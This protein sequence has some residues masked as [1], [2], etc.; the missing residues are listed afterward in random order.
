MVHPPTQVE[1]AS[2]QVV[3]PEDGWT[4]VDTSTI[5]KWIQRSRTGANLDGG[6]VGRH[7]RVALMAMD[8]VGGDRGG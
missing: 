2:P 6:G 4:M 3:K 1:E 7:R 5:P 8:A